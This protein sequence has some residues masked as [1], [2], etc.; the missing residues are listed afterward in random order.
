MQSNLRMY[1]YVC[2]LACVPES[3]LNCAWGLSRG[4]A[5]LSTGADSPVS[6][7]SL[8]TA[9]PVSSSTS[10]GSTMLVACRQGQGHG[11]IRRRQRDKVSLEAVTAVESV[12]SGI[13]REPRSSSRPREVRISHEG[14]SDKETLKEVG[15]HMTF[16]RGRLKEVGG[17]LLYSRRARH[18]RAGGRRW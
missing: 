6:I 14:E 16:D 13:A 11:K 3:G 15:G 10:Q 4:R 17:L 2:V 8:I 18:R 9:H 12:S 7:A 1:M 5:A